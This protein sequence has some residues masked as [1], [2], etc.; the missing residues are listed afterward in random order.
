MDEKVKAEGHVVLLTQQSSRLRE[1]NV[2]SFGKPISSLQ[3]SSH[4]LKASNGHKDVIG[5]YAKHFQVMS[6]P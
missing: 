6:V 5:N 3:I 1:L 2:H 4:S